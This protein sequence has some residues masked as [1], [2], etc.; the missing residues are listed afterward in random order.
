MAQ[1]NLNFHG[2]LVHAACQVMPTSISRTGDDSA[3]YV[4]VS[5]ITV[6]IDTAHNACGDKTVPVGLDYQALSSSQS[7]AVQ[8]RST[9]QTGVLTVTYQ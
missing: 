1:G 4:Q 3:R 6:R 7:L 5:G 2:T 8:N 9:S